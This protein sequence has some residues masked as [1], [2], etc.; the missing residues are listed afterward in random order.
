M[1][2][3]RVFPTCKA[4]SPLESAQSGGLALRE[5]MAP[6]ISCFCVQLSWVLRLRFGSISWQDT[7]KASPSLRMTARLFLRL[8]LS[9]QVVRV[10]RILSSASIRLELLQRLIETLRQNKK[11]RAP[12]AT[13]A[14]LLDI[15]GGGIKQAQL[16]QLR[17][18]LR[19]NTG[20]MRL[21]I[22]NGFLGVTPARQ[23][24]I[25]GRIL[26]DGLSP[27]QDGNQLVLGKT[28]RNV[29]S[30]SEERCL[31]IRPRVQSLLAKPSRRLRRLWLGGP[32]NSLSG[33]PKA[34]G[35]R[36]RT[37]TFLKRPPVR[38]N[39]FERT[40]QQ[41]ARATLLRPPNSETLYWACS[42]INCSRALASS[43][44]SFN[45]C[46]NCAMASGI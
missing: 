44:L 18:I 45:A 21:D 26:Q 28:L 14:N 22:G 5:G 29:I 39:G 37:C 3:A 8:S 9:S 20:D 7:Y 11:R 6:D 17:S 34:T 32:D 40:G 13:D 12:S 27:A 10:N 31:L 25:I 43:G 15:P 19:L 42:L 41:I 38:S 36:P 1:R 24:K 16:E 33:W 23:D 2:I 35:G 4:N 30:H 46:S